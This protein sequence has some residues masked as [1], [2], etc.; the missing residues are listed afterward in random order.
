MRGS[1]DHHKTGSPSLNHGKMPREYASSK[2]GLPSPPP[3]ARRPLGSSSARS[4]GGNGS[5]GP[6]KG[7][8][9]DCQHPSRTVVMVWFFERHGTYIRC[10]TRDATEGGYELVIT[11]DGSENVE[12]FE[13]SAALTRRQRELDL[14][15]AD[16]GWTGPVRPHHLTLSVH[17]RGDHSRAFL[18]RGTRTHEQ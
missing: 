18:A 17:S 13:D 2:R 3:A 16:D 8:M 6:S 4:V 14:H 7:I 9:L 1:G 15:L 12:R 5:N 11:P 10:E